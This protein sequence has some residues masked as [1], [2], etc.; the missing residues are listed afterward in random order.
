MYGLEGIRGESAM[1]RIEGSGFGA[2]GRN[3]ITTRGFVCAQLIENDAIIRT[4][5][6]KVKKLRRIIIAL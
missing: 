4:L 2:G 6:G 1:G 5:Q 3:D